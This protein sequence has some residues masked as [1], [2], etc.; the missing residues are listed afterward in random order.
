MAILYTLTVNGPAGINPFPPSIVSSTWLE[1]IQQY[2]S[3]NAVGGSPTF[4]IV[5]IFANQSALDNFIITYKLTDSTLISDL[6]AWKS[7]HNISFNSSYY[8]LT[9]AGITPTPDPIIS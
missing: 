5:I 3:N 6:N 9:D 7:A 1:N 2:L 4:P 8:N